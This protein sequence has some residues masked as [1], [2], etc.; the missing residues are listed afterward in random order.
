MKKTSWK[1][2]WSK[3]FNGTNVSIVLRIGSFT[4][5]V[6][7]FLTN[8]HKRNM[9]ASKQIAGLRMQSINFVIWNIWRKKKHK[10]ALKYTSRKLE[11]YVYNVRAH[12]LQ[13]WGK[14]VTGKIVS[15]A[16]LN[17]YRK[18]YTSTSFWLILEIKWDEKQKQQKLVVRNG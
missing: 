9:Q 4:C 2:N 12:K 15:K 13:W 6:V 18:F 3:E 17:T 16:Y 1:S 7:A 8:K 11:W 5:T 10:L 14:K